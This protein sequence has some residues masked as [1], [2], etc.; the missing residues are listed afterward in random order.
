MKK[1]LILNILVSVIIIT[2]PLASITK[3]SWSEAEKDLPS[4]KLEKHSLILQKPKNIGTS[5]VCN[6][7]ARQKSLMT[8]YY[9]F[10]SPILYPFT[11]R[12]Y[13]HLLRLTAPRSDRI[14]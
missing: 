8:C 13:K 2:T 12:L 4:A 6:T 14:K 9:K 1:K 7:S 10:R 11:S 5:E 3:A